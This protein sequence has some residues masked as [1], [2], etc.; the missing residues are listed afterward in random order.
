MFAPIAYFMLQPTYLCFESDTS[1]WYQCTSEVFCEDSSIKYVVDYT[2]RMSFYNW[3]VQ[4]NLECASESQLQIITSAFFF[5]YL[6][7]AYHISRA[8]DTL[9]RKWTFLISQY[10]ILASLAIITWSS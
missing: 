3:I 4:Y 2:D 6:L 1:E 10:V 5:G 9:S 8:G 7:F